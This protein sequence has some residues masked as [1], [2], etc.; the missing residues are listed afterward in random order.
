MKWIKSLN[1]LKQKEENIFFALNI[2]VTFEFKLAYR[3]WT[4]KKGAMLAVVQLCFRFAL[5][6]LNRIWKGLCTLPPIMNSLTGN[7]QTKWPKVKNSVL[8]SNA[9]LILETYWV[10][11]SQ[12]HGERKIHT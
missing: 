11:M 4:N 2:C 3:I 8:G 7:S 5:T 12:N 6:L 10:W 1:V 9:G